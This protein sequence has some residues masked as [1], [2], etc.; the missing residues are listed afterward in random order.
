MDASEDLNAWK[1]HPLYSTTPH[2]KNRTQTSFLYSPQLTPQS[3]QLR[4]RVQTCGCPC[5]CATIGPVLPAGINSN[6]STPLINNTNPSIRKRACP[7]DSNKENEAPVSEPSTPTKKKVR[8]YKQRRSIDDKLNDIFNEIEEADWSLSHFLFY[9]FRHKG[10]DGKDIHRRKAHANTVQKFLAGNTRYTPADILMSW[11]HTPD[12]RLDRESDL[13]YSVL[14]P[15]SNIKP[16]RPCL[17]SFAVQ[18]VEQQL[19][20]EARLATRPSS[21]LHAVVSRKS[22][23]I[24]KTEW[25]DIGATTV[26]DIARILQ[27]FQPLTWHYFTNIAN[28]K[29]RVRNGVVSIRKHRPAEAVSDF[30]TTFRKPRHS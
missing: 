28:R 4:S 24:K 9:V 8:R 5:N 3:S 17:T 11:F 25:A 27:K 15:Y 6:P 1:Y 16:V 30:D 7:R 21:G 13:M 14:I 10:D 2:H 22:S 19:L 12:G 20:R 18:I 29:S 26:P 23:N